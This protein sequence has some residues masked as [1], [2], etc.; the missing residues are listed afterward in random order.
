[1]GLLQ[2]DAATYLTAKKTARLEGLDIT[3]AEIADLIQQR[4]EAR[5]SKDWA[6]SDSIREQLLRQG[7]ELKDNSQGTTWEVTRG[8]SS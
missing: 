6:K 1:M 2:E 5:M 4:Q 3:E 8:E 7:I